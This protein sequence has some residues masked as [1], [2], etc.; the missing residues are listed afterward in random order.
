MLV[1]GVR[2]FCHFINTIHEKVYFSSLYYLNED[3]LPDTKSI[4]SGL[5]SFVSENNR[6]SGCVTSR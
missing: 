2:T 6:L 4:I 1:K 5:L 3:Q